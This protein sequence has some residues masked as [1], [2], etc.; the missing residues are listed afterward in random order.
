MANHLVLE[1]EGLAFAPHPMLVETDRDKYCVQQIVD[2]YKRQNTDLAGYFQAAWRF[3]HRAALGQPRATLA[4]LAAERQV[5]P[6]YL[7]TVW[8]ALEQEKHDGRADGPA[9]GDVARAARPGGSRASDADALAKPGAAAMRD[10]VVGL[11]K[12]LE[13]RFTGRRSPGLQATSQPLAMWRNR[14]YASHRMTC[15]REALQIEGKALLARAT[16]AKKP[17]DEDAENDEEEAPTGREERKAGAR[18]RPGRPRRPAGPLRRRPSI[19]SAPSS[20]TPST[21][22]SAAATTWTRPGTRAACSAPA[23]TT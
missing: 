1:S 16:T 10:F 20:P 12:K 18:S 3:R 19:A 6:R 23:S 7:A 9:A 8:R 13:P 22:P 2:F 14:Q 15:D 4:S 5:S 17:A 11:R 21:S